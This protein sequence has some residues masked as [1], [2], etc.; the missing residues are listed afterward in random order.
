[1]LED[2]KLFATLDTT[3]RG[4]KLSGKQEILLTDTVGFIRKLPHHLVEAFKS[5]LEEACCADILIHVVDASSP[6][7]EIQMGV[8][9]ETL[10]ELG[11][12]DK[13]VITVFNKQDLLMERRICRDHHAE[14][15][16]PA[17]AKLGEGLDD[18]R[19]AIEKILREQK[20]YIERL[21]PYEKAGLIQLIRKK[22]ELLTE[23]YRADGI[24]VQAYVSKEI[25]VKI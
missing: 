12:G 5:T 20:I 3:T 10:R 16:I 2:A 23:E 22:G 24:Y 25:Y 18:I 19:H 17:S 11:A 7:M 9:Y 1:M 6:Q 15:C 8:V 4:V 14:V 21:Y 13:P